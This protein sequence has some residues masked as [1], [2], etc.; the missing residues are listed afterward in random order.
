MAAVQQPV[1]L[2]IFKGRGKIK[3]IEGAGKAFQGIVQISRR[4]RVFADD[5]VV[6]LA[7]TFLLKNSGDQKSG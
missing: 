1:I 3:K 7:G 6:E 4:F 2:F 5:Q